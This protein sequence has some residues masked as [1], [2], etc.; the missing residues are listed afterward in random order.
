MAPRS[1]QQFKEMRE[2]S[3][4]LI[5]ETALQLFAEKG[6][7]ATS[8]NAIAKAAGISKGL[9]YNYFNSKEELVQAIIFM[10]FEEGDKM[11][12]G[13][14]QYPPEQQLEMVFEAYFQDIV[15]NEQF[16]KLMVSLAVQVDQFPFI[17][18]PVQ[19]KMQGYYQIIGNLLKDIDYPHPE[20]E[21]KEVAALFDGIGIQYVLMGKDYPLDEMKHHLIQK[22]CRTNKT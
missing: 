2:K 12:E 21:A 5:R 13:I 14:D 3:R 8:M 7:H 20:S 4:Q 19:Q 18:E 15:E 16:W 11:M 9:L 17:R 6:Y 10:A 22:Y 1:H